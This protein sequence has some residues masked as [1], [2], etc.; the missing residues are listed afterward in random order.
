MDIMKKDGI[1]ITMVLAAT[2]LTA[3]FTTTQPVYAQI[4]S[5]GDT[6]DS[7]GDETI[8]ESNSFTNEPTQ[9]ANVECGEGAT[10]TVSQESESNGGGPVTHGPI[11]T[12]RSNIKSL[13]N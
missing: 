3:I 1:V 7:S 13:L 6:Q 10:C 12:S 9:T 5:N 2:L 4:E 8:T 11:S